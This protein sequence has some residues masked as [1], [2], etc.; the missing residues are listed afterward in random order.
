MVVQSAL[1]LAD[2]A[3]THDG[4][5][6][7]LVAAGRKVT[8]PKRTYSVGS[9]GKR[10]PELKYSGGYTRGPITTSQRG[11]G[12]WQRM[13][14]IS[15]LCCIGSRRDRTRGISYKDYGP[16]AKRFSQL[17][18]PQFKLPMRA[19]PGPLWGK[20]ENATPSILTESTTTTQ[21]FVGVIGGRG[22]GTRSLVNTPTGARLDQRTPL[23]TYIVSHDWKVKGK[24]SAP[25]RGLG[26]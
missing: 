16:Y 7:V 2:F 11:G 19:P 15:L 5:S 4:T 12:F 13:E 21:G 25:T 6:G 3:P 14:K 9:Y 20:R 8:C 1:T 18:E 22:G 10:L 24:G 23:T 26:I 17:G